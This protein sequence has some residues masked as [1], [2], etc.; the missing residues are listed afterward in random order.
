MELELTQTT[1][2]VSSRPVDVQLL[3]LFGTK[4]LTSGGTDKLF[5]QTFGGFPGEKLL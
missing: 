1:V 3:D 5:Q 2:R 4:V